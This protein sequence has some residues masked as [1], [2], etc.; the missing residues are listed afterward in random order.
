MD[1][2]WDGDKGGYEHWVEWLCEIMRE[3]L[4]VLKPGAHG[5]VWALP[6]VSDWTGRALRLAGFEIKD[7]CIHVFG[8]GM[9][10]GG[11]VYKKGS[12]K[13]DGSGYNLKPAVE[14]WW[15][16][17]KPIHAKSVRK[18]KET[19]GTGA[20][21]INDCR[22]EHSETCKE[23]KPQSKA[24]LHNPR[25]RQGG[26]HKTTLELKPEG[27]WPSHL[28]L[29]HSEGCKR[30]GKKKVKNPSGDLNGNVRNE[31]AS[32]AYGQMKQPRHF[33]AYG[34]EN[35]MELLDDWQC[36]DSCPVLLMESQNSGNVSRY[37]KQFEYEPLHYVPKPKKS[38][39]A[40]P[41]LGEEND[42]NTVKPVKLMQEYVRLIT[43]KGGI[44][45]DP[46]C[47]SGTTGVAAMME[48]CSFIGIEI[49]SEMCEVARKRMAWRE[50]SMF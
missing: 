12:L 9:P 19:F 23:M 39:K 26:R 25:L 37:F 43:P 20:L 14:F 8:Q 49:D 28:Q 46:F 1:L 18:N 24:S 21:N 17:Q 10:K 44:V 31:E 15:L 33:K 11:T 4:R 40:R 41:G 22:I 7:V 30:V 42:H 38:E 3:A 6:K 2:D 29:T 34:D 32:N 16:I 45:L 36:A 27:R 35:G 47:G 50:M 48:G 13:D 5:L